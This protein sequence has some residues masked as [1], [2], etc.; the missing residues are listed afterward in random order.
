MRNSS[1][2]EN[3]H[4]SPFYRE[5][6]DINDFKRYLNFNLNHGLCG[7]INLGNTCFMNSSIACLSNCTE[8]T[9]YFLS[10]K[11][12]NDINRYNYDGAKGKLAEEWYK[13]LNVYWNS[14][15]KVGNPKSI[16]SIVGSKNRKFLGYN[17]QDSNEFMTVFLEILGEDL[18]RTTKKKYVE[19]QEQQE[20][21]TDVQAANRF[22]SLHVQRNN[23]I[24]T[25]LFHGL[26]KSTITCPKCNF[27]S[28]T[29]DPFNTL[30]LTIP[31]IR[32][33]NQYNQKRKKIVKIHKKKV[34]EIKTIT[35]CFVPPLSY[36]KI[37]KYKIEVNKKVTLEE[38]KNEL[39]NRENNIKIQNNFKF[40]SVSKG[41]YK[42][43]L[44]KRD[45]IDKDSFVYG[46]ETERKDKSDYISFPIYLRTDEYLSE[47][48]RILFLDK[49]TSYYDFKK[50][51]YFIVRKYLKHP[52]YNP[53]EKE[54]FELDN[55][56][57]KY[58]K[59]KSNRLDKILSLLEKEFELLYSNSQLS[60][61]YNK[62]KP[63]KIYISVS[64]KED[65]EYLINQGNY[66]N[67]EILE[68]FHIS[69]NYN[70]V[71]EMLKYI[72][73]KKYFLI[74]HISTNSALTK[75][76]ISLDSFSTEISLP[77]KEEDKYEEEEMEVEEDDDE[78]NEYMKS[79]NITLDHCLQYFTEE[80]CLEE[81]NEWYCSKCR[82]RVMASK[83]IELFYL[84]RI[85]C[86]C[87]TRFSKKG[88]FYDY[89]KNNSLVEF[90]IENLNMGKYICGPDKKFAKYDLF[91]ISQHYGSMGGGHYTAVCK[92]ID[93]N[94]YEYDDSYCQRTS[95]NNVCT[96]AAYVLF[97]RRQNW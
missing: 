58:V 13:L 28:I 69:S 53:K 23:S 43:E 39:E 64:L 25:D 38:V 48:P 89:T 95:S 30:A 45:I 63:Y 78:D 14:S 17:Q 71:D 8:L 72:M 2:K 82:R 11:Y 59:G 51:I 18:N 34:K 31:D 57:S 22:W 87:L 96:N 35:V 20:R 50:Y 77:L 97:Y 76:N 65:K 1:I 93:G 49:N 44:D 73:K 79:N 86:I 56:L 85:L 19:L 42:K 12:I 88:R 92:N 3:Y 70:Y 15:N 75:R 60:N 47:Y 5:I 66:N 81:G 16:K 68:L 94:W 74:V 37:K 46:Y 83:Q 4:Q 67:I 80:E 33:I 41:V 6:I 32:R 84:P 54:E 10:K 36:R 61:N 7:S 9:A 91:A 21:E 62:Y 24:V 55:E 26:L 27:H 29:Y 40:F 52:L 90:P